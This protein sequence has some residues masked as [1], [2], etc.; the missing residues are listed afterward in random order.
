MPP[1]STQQYHT[2]SLPPPPKC[3]PHAEPLKLYLSVNIGKSREALKN[4]AW[5]HDNK[6]KPKLSIVTMK[7]W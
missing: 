2:Q 7:A 4:M 1:P 6:K 3:F 5:E